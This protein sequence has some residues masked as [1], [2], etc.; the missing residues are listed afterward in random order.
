MLFSEKNESGQLT[1]A[2]ARKLRNRNRAWTRAAVQAVFF[3]SMPGAFVA[4]F[5]G[6]KYIFRQIGSGGVL[7]MNSFVLSLIGLAAFTI[8]FGRFFCGYLC[9]FGTLGD[10]TYWLSGLFQ[11]KILKRKRQFSLP[12]KVFPILQK[13]KY[14]NLAFIVAVT[15]LGM[16]GSLQ[17]TS[18]WDVF[19]RLTA[20]RLPADGYRI[21]ILCL[22]LVV[23]GMALQS[24]FFCQ[25]LCPLG[26]FFA[27]LP[28][29]PFAQ[30]RRDPEKCLPRCNACRNQCPVDLKLEKDGFRNGECI[31]CEKCAGIC[32]RDNL[33]YSANAVVKS[34]FLFTLLRAALFFALGTWLGFCRFL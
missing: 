10:L 20:L 6:I 28:M 1:A 17:G 22:V 11:A 7:E 24:R 27:V 34:E 13:L 8:L 12:K 16:A 25:F 21:G 18:A 3:V 32:P 23:I 5:N 15:A 19:S 9:A 26:A 2:Q 30:L 33:R 29:L 4:G 14:L 31:S